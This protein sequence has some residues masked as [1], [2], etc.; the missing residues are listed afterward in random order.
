MKIS[1]VHDLPN[2]YIPQSN[3]CIKWAANK[4]IVIQRIELYA[5]HC[6]TRN[7]VKTQEAN[8]HNS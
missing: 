1:P 2:R 7:Q 8:M 6:Q 4:I 5:S 3:L